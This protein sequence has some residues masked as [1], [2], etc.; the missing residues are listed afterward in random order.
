MRVKIFTDKNL[1]RHLAKGWS[2]QALVDG[3]VS[4]LT[5]RTLEV[6]CPADGTAR[7][8]KKAL[9]DAEG[10]RIEDQ[11][12]KTVYDQVMNDT[13]KLSDHGV[14]PTSSSRP[15]ILI[16]SGLLP[17]PSGTCHSEASGLAL[18]INN[19]TQ[20]I[21]VA[22]P[23]IS[24]AASPAPDP[25][26]AHAHEHVHSKLPPHAASATPHPQGAATCTADGAAA[27]EAGGIRLGGGCGGSGVGGGSGGV[28]DSPA[29][30][31]ARSLAAAEARRAGGAG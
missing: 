29:L 25:S 21:T 26:A 11:I 2:L 8:V 10:W 17:E 18:A 1:H 28:E 9:E 5:A 24:P 3:K 6:E 12:L 14:T 20:T 7:S 19:P 31:R 22:A 23:P 30:R 27:R 16:M 15:L 13:D 4:T